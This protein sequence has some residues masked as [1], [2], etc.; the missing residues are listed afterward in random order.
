[1]TTGIDELIP[2]REHV[3][4]LST[5]PRIDDRT[6][7][8]KHG[9][10]FAVFDRFGDIELFGAGEQGIYHLDTRFLSRL[11]LMLEGMRPLLL[12]STI[13]DDNAVLAV[14]AM[15]HDIVRDDEEG[16]ARGTV[17]VFRS[18]V[19]WDGACFERVRV[20]NY[21]RRPVRL[22]LSLAVDADFVDMFEVRGFVRD[23]QR[24]EPT[25]T[26]EAGALVFRYE[27]LDGR[28]RQTRLTFEPAPAELDRGE[29]AFDV[30]LDPGEQSEYQFTISC[31]IDEPHGRSVRTRPP[32][33]S[34]VE[35]A[36]AALHRLRGESP[37][38]DSSNERLNDWL[39]RSVAD[40][41]MLRTGTPHGPYPYA[42][43]PWFCAPFG[44]DGILT[45][46]ECLSFVPELARGVLSFLAATQADAENPERDAE[47]GKILHEARAGEMAATGEVPFHRYYGA[48]DGTPL[49]V[50]LAGAYFERTG[51]LELIRSLWPNLERAL[52]WID[53]YGDGD[54]DG[55]V[56]Y[57]KRSSN[58]LLQ[59]GWKDSN[60]TVFHADGRDAAGPIALCE[61]QGYVYG[62]KRA[63]AQLLAALGDDAR[64][65]ELD[66]AAETLRQ[67]FEDAFWCDELDTYA[68]ALDGEKRPC[69]VRSSNAGHCLFSGIAS[70]ER[71]RRV[72]A[73]L[74]SGASYS[75]W[76]IRTIAAGEAR[77]NPMSYHNGSIWPHDNAIIA[78]GFARY[79]LVDQ[80]AQVFSGLLD[81][82][83]F[84]DQHRLPELFCGF[85]RRAGEAPTLYPVA[86]SPQ[87]WAAA[88]AYSLL[89]SCLGLRVLGSERRIVLTN[90]VLP[91]QVRRVSLRNL[92][93]GESSLDL[94]ARRHAAGDVGVNVVRRQGD[95]QVEIR[96]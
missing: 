28:R 95:V 19:L 35:E 12:S 46:L 7:V 83:L 52:R 74:T 29:A 55:F 47:P 41:D 10:T 72:T 3:Y 64:A 49:F 50:L 65:A 82:S 92:R 77:Y 93:F 11:T 4:V 79:G 58:G 86:C 57:S 87:A 45:A 80:A 90:P 85:H 39:N 54:G 67:R 1:M 8:L 69:R 68:L 91:P 76:G 9:D 27:G 89:A 18:K 61:V 40:L 32:Y 48:V 84:F 24:R 15:N 31:E 6:R 70:P 81:A 73:T 13:K 62:A 21:G 34:A 20:Q 14:D 78:A 25:V 71:A 5:S 2:V 63:A 43:V 88:A 23:R 44:R 53:E 60:D 66:S 51:D 38:I 59:Q 56:E 96:K 22:R 75:G 36:S 16:I 26:T 17:H 33:E 37:A 30:R 42:G 94:E